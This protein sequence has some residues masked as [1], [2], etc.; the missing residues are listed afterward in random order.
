MPRT[1]RAEPSREEVSMSFTS[2]DRL[3]LLHDLERL[4][5]L[6]VER[7]KEAAR[8]LVHR[9]RSLVHEYECLV[10]ALRRGDGRAGTLGGPRARSA[11]PLPSCR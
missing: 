7:R 2:A 9:E 11:T 4:G 10:R 5:F 8:L 1:A 3:I 6:T